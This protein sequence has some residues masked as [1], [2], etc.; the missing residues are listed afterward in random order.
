MSAPSLIVG[1]TG[2]IASGKSTVARLFAQLGVPVV[3][4]DAVAREV[5]APGCE[6]LQAIRARFGDQVLSADGQL[7]RARLRA[8]V[9]ADESARKD[10]ERLVH[11]HVRRIMA[12]RLRAADAPYAIAMVPLLLETGMQ[13]RYQRVLVVDVSRAT[14]LERARDRDG[15]SSETLQGILEAQLDRDSRLALADDV[16]DN[17]GVPQDLAAQVERLHAYYLAMA[18]RLRAV[19]QQ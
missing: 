1:L 12:Q 10:L 9:F 3:D 11:P 4:A 18:A 8:L 19:P 5:V 7:N 16:I 17:E 15:S 13:D 6:A 14:Q 2:G